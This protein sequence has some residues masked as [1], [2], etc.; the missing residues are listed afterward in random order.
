MS[1]DGTQ[2][3]MKP[4]SSSP[5]AGAL[6]VGVVV[7]D[8]YEITGLLGK[9]GMGAVWAARHLR[10]P[11]KRVAIKVLLGGAQQG[12]DA[13]ALARFKREAE[14]ASRIGHAGIV[15]VLDFNQLPDGTPYQVLEYL[16]GE[17]LGARLG[18]GALPVATALD[19][20]RQIGSALAA[21]H[22]AGVIHRDLKPENIFLCPTDAGGVVS[23]RVK[24][25]DFGI[26]KIRGSQTVKTQDQVLIGTPQY[27]APEQAAG[28]NAA[29]DARTDLFALGAI[30]YEMLA[31]KPPFSGDS[32]VAVIMAVVSS[33]PEPL[34]TL[35]PEA[36]ASVI[37]AVERALAK[38]PEDRFPDVATF[39]EALTGKP[40]QTLGGGEGAASPGA[41]APLSREEIMGATVAPAYGSPALTGGA[42]TGAP[43]IAVTTAAQPPAKWPI[44]FAAF[45]VVVG[46]VSFIVSTHL[47][48]SGQV[49]PA[50]AAVAAPAPPA[51]SAHV[52]HDPSPPAPTS[53][54]VPPTPAAKEPAHAAARSHAEAAIPDAVRAELDAAE[55][56]LHDGDLAQAKR[57]AQHSLLGQRTSRAFSI[58]ARVACEQSDLANAR[59]ALHNVTAADDKA[60]VRREC[61][62]AGINLR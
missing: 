57:L 55:D 29:I 54:P 26:S 20:A 6:G 5:S 8:A 16:A 44:W 39:I 9:G 52:V 2:P 53:P 51:P 15:E 19:F 31:G 43:P 59:G 60:T 49:H 4:P 3:T 47:Q 56:Q 23:E 7:A 1:D 62:A 17:S 21:A 46:I 61:G 35:A 18:R 14:V 27:M 40:L 34:A 45:F 24:V 12:A 50:P 58:L 11:G 38:K 32:V 42:P 33:T 30:V 41:R 13:Q 25:L 22:R 37:A 28:K 36:P 10:L 48:R